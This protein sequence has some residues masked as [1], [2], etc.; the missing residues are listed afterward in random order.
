[1]A[2][3]FA[4]SVSGGAAGTKSPDKKMTREQIVGVMQVMQRAWI[5]KDPVALAAVHAEDSVVYSPMFG[6]V[7][8]RAEIER[9]YRRC[10]GRSR[11]GRGRAA[12]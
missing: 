4:M 6:E 11:T 12:I 1:L 10:S 8:G 3:E 5:A 2:R 7:H 9:T